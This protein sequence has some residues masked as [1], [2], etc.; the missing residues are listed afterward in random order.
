MKN[1]SKMKKEDVLDAVGKIGGSIVKGAAKVAGGIV[2]G[3]KGIGDQYKK[4][5]DKSRKYVGK[6]SAKP[7][8]LDFDKDGNKNEPMKKALKDKEKAMKENTIN[9]IK[10][11]ANNNYKKADGALAAIVNE[12]IKQRIAVANQNLSIQR[13]NK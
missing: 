7:D 12:K 1:N 6:E 4:S 10:H 3:V 13:G 11:V 2:G 9:F 5:R 8:Y